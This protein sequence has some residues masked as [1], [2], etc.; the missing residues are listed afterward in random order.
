[1][2]DYTL[3]LSA[4]NKTIFLPLATKE[5][6][7]A[8]DDYFEKAGDEYVYNDYAYYLSVIDEKGESSRIDSIFVNNEI[9]ENSSFLSEKKPLDIFRECFGIIKI[10]AVVMVFHMLLRI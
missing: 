2:S 1:M 7:D 8:F 6:D 4:N 10:E 5:I 9:I 3:K